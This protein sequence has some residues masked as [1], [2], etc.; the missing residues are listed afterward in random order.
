MKQI[1]PLW[2]AKVSEV[3]QKDRRRRAFNLLELLVVML[4]IGLM[5]A[6]TLSSLGKTLPRYK[7]RGK[8]TEVSGFFQK[9]RLAAIKSGL[10]VSV[11]IEAMGNS[12]QALIAYRNNIDGTKTELYR[13]MAGS[14]TRPFDPYLG[15]VFGAS[16]DAGKTVTFAAGK[17]V[18]KATG[19]AAETG[20]IRVSIG[21]N[22]SMN[23][24]EVAISSLGGQPVLR[25]Y[26]V[27]DDL[28]PG[29]PLGQ[30]FFK[31]THFGTK[32]QWVWY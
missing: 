28:P 1:P 20:A 5:A 24:I 26:T 30:E 17:V 8:A 19:N 10:D 21:Q 16:V 12:E 14:P 9:A 25:K 11:E 2:N 23:T 4:L 18:Y 15:G 31:E 13:L 29:A 3:A 7:L 22:D 32:W 27:S 6:V